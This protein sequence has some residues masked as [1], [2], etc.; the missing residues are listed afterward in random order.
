MSCVSE[1]NKAEQYKQFRPCRR[2]WMTPCSDRRILHMRH[3]TVLSGIFFRKGALT[4]IH[5]QFAVMDLV[6]W[7]ISMCISYTLE[8]KSSLQ[9]GQV[10]HFLVGWDELFGDATG[11]R[12]VFTLVGANVYVGK[13]F[14]LLPVG[15]R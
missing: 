15:I 1:K 12:G 14:I 5:S 9:C 2:C 7:A 10:I 11:L 8:G 6:L 4:A 3:F 13:P